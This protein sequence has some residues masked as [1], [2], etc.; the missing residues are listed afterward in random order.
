MALP[1]YQNIGVAAGGGVGPI[2][3]PNRGEATRG[4]DAIGGAINAMSEAFFKE[5]QIAAVEEGEKY[6]AEKA[7]T[8]EQIRLAIEANQP[9]DR[10]GDSRTFFGKAADKAYGEVVSTQVQYMARTDL[11]KI[12]SDAESGA[13]APGEIVPAVNSVITGYKTALAQVDPTLARRVEAQLAYDGNN[14]FLAA[15]K[16][17]A[18]G[19]PKQ[20]E[21]DIRDT[22]MD[23]E[24]N[25]PVVVASGPTIDQK[26]G[27][28]LTTQDKIKVQRDL[29]EAAA[30]RTNKPSYVERTLRNFDKKANE[31]VAKYVADWATDPDGNS[32]AR[33]RELQSG[34]INDPQIADIWAKSDSGQRIKILNEAEV[35]VTKR[36]RFNETMTTIEMNNLKREAKGI[37]GDFY[38]NLFEN[39]IPGQEKAIERLRAVDPERAMKLQRVMIKADASDDDDVVR[40]IELD[41]AR[42]T[43]T[44]ERVKSALEQDLISSKTARTWITAVRAEDTADFRAAVDAAKDDPRVRYYDAIDRQT[45]IKN[46]SRVRSQLREEMIANPG[47]KPIDLLEGVI[48]RTMKKAE[49]T[50]FSSATGAANRFAVEMKLTAREGTYSVQE[51]Q[52]RLLSDKSKMS[53]QDFDRISRALKEIEGAIVAGRKVEGF[54]K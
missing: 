1:R 23:L 21:A 36:A 38:N 49:D 9:L 26:T 3:F 12:R 53:P 16:R 24:E 4:L 27:A 25:L 10:V 5:A 51:M 35:S 33:V 54:R 37:E 46:L 6:G 42:G 20:L 30:R 14:I 19:V 17:A 15:T 31:V 43:L 32:V 2:D 44:E 18:S 52:R 48:G 50:A 13:I 41:Y 28:V 34:K 39:N 7:P 45:G 11:A 8:Q 29:I 40:G 22:I 47:K